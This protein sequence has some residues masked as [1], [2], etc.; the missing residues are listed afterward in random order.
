MIDRMCFNAICRRER[1]SGGIG[2]IRDDSGHP[3]RPAFARAGPHDGFH[4][5]TPPGNQ[6]DNFF[7]R[8]IL[9]FDARKTVRF[10]V[11]QRGRGV[12]R[13]VR[14]FIIGRFAAIVLVALQPT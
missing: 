11:A 12:R 8:A 2:A 6:D 1:K 5:G 10:G 7:H 9:S 13:S 3:G 14:A 4:V